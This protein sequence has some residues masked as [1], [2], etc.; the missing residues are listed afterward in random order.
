MSVKKIEDVIVKLNDEII[1]EVKSKF[2]KSEDGKGVKSGK[3]TSGFYTTNSLLDE[4]I[5]NTLKNNLVEDMVIKLNSIDG[6]KLNE[7]TSDINIVKLEEN[8]VEVEFINT[9]K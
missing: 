6:D 7:L 1:E 3:F 4:K 9:L 2:E 5:V 8:E